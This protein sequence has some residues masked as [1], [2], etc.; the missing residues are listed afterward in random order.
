MVA[1][2]SRTEQCPLSGYRDI[3][4]FMCTK[5]GNVSCGKTPLTWPAV[6]QSRI[7]VF[8]MPAVVTISTCCVMFKWRL[9][10]FPESRQTGYNVSF[11][12]N[13]F[14]VVDKQ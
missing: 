6:E 10:Q 8:R 2:T 4:E 14:C 11:V 12:R 9:S 3:S 7:H 13:L 5:Y 1:G